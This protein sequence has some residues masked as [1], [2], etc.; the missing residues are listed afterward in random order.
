[1]SEAVGRDL[2]LHTVPFV[3]LFNAPQLRICLLSCV[4]NSHARA[5]RHLLGASSQLS[6]QISKTKT[7]VAHSDRVGEVGIL[8]RGARQGRLIRASLSGLCL[9][10]FT[11]ELCQRL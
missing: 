4:I 8:I 9:L 6:A 7:P 1:M 3:R 5:K 10:G 11:L 2:A